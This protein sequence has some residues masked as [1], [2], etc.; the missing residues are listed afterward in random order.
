[1]VYAIVLWCTCLFYSLL[2]SIAFGAAALPHVDISYT[3]NKRSHYYFTNLTEKIKQV[4]LL[5]ACISSFKVQQ[6]NSIV[7][8]VTQDDVYIAEFPIS[9]NIFD[10]WA[11]IPKP[12]QMRVDP[13]ICDVVYTKRLPIFN[14]TG[15]Q[16]PGYMSPSAPRCQTKYLKWICEQAR[17]PIEEVQPNHFS[18]PEADHRSNLAAPPPQPWLITAR[19]AIVSLC[20]QVSLSCG[21]IRCIVYLVE[22][23]HIFA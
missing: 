19:N 10:W 21:K 2:I 17:L 12:R 5:N 14:N 3:W 20:G 4:S 11:N 16:L 6:H 7:V 23:R 15:C 13:Y 1:M 9:K 8:P 22:V 18:I